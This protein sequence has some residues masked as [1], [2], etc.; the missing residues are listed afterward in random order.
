MEQPNWSFLVGW[1]M[2]FV[3][4]ACIVYVFVTA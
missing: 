3:V 1:S 2:G 4:G